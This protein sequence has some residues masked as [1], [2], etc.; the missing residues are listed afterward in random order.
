MALKFAEKLK[1]I[2]I[3]K[4]AMPNIFGKKTDKENLDNE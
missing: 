4:V 1:G 2:E 3:P